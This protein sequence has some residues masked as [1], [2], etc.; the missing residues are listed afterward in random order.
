FFVA[1]AR[2]PDAVAAAGA[3]QRALEAG[4]IRV[5]MGIH[6][7]EPLVAEDGYVGIDVHR[8]ARICSTAHG[9]QI[10][11]SERTRALIDDGFRVADLGLHRLK[12]L[13]EPAKLFQLGKGDFPPLRSLNATNLPTQP[14]PLVGRERELAEVLRLLGSARLVTLTGAGGSGKTRL[15]LQA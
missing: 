14:T 8:A 1:F 10:V 3:G 2:A 7:G 15:A 5:R 11:F 6:T 9:G 4:P 13:V 12:D